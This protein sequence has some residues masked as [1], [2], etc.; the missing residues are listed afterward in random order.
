MAVVMTESVAVGCKSELVMSMWEF[1]VALLLAVW[2]VVWREVTGWVGNVVKFF[3]MVCKG[4][5]WYMLVQALLNWRLAV[6]FADLSSFQ[7]LVG[8][9]R[10][11]ME[12]NTFKGK[13]KRWWRGQEP[14]YPEGFE[15][16]RSS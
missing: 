12:A 1:M 9:V 14:V 5:M 13:W 7:N 3:K 4:Y 8:Y 6:S 2:T 11:L 16:V 10:F 15:M